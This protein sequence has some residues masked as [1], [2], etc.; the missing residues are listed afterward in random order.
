MDIEFP[1]KLSVPLFEP[2]RYKILY[3]GRGASRSWSSARALLLK[4]YYDKHRIL[5]A[6]EFQNSISDS[7][8]A[9]LTQQ[10][11]LLGLNHF[12]EVQNN[13]IIGK[14]GTQF[15]FAGL[16]HN[17]GTIR[18]KEGITIAWVEEA[19]NLSKASW[20]VLIPTIRTDGSEI[21]M[22]FNPDLET[23]ETYQRFVA[24]PPKNSVV[25][26][27]NFHDNPWFPEVLRQEMEDLK[28]RDYDAYLN[29]WEGHCKQT[30]E[31][32]IFAKE[33]RNALQEGRIG[34]VPPAPGRPIDTFW[35]LGK[36]DHTSVWFVQFLGMGEYRVVDFYQNRAEDLPHYMRML[37]NKNYVYGLHWLP[38]D[39]NHDRLGMLSIR[40]QMLAVY[41]DRVRVLERISRK[42]IGIE[43][44]RT[45]FPLCHFDQ[46]KC[47]DGLQ[48]LRHYKYEVDPITGQYSKNPEHDENSD[49]ADAFLQI[50][51]GVNAHKP[52]PIVKKVEVSRNGGGDI[53]TGWMGQ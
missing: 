53:G 51:M 2:Y 41:P 31:G 24:N 8:H 46:E 48:A 38:H 27:M 32:A 35:D 19:Q 7:V 16:R 45:I 3:G 25:I 10:I 22:T 30:V 36:R 18:S 37:Q 9:L 13:A 28:A 52:K 14:N 5:C 4:G 33:L 50:A 15:T 49:A 34:K 6:R 17:I 23:D 43:A 47:A 12:Y 21:W 42:Q 11:S 44:A 20:D 1:E 26:W 29:I 39:G 40:R